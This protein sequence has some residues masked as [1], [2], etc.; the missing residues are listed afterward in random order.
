MAVNDITQSQLIK[1]VRDFCLNFASPALKDIEHVV[2]G[3]TN[4]LTPPSV[5]NDL[6]V[7]TP[8][9]ERRLHTT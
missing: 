6:C 3:Y 2:V 5:G 1:S 9:S 8:I 7:V 4:N